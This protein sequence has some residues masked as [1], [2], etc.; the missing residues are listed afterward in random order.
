MFVE[1]FE[2]FNGDLCSF[3]FCFEFFENDYFEN[4][5]FEKKFWWCCVCDGMDVG[6]V[7]EFVEIKWKFV[8][9]DLIGGFFDFVYKNWVEDQVGENKEL[10]IKKVFIEFMEKI[11]FG[12]ISFFIWF[13]FCGCK[14]IVEDDKIGVKVEEELCKKC[15]VGEDIFDEDDEEFDEDEYEYEV[16]FIGDDFVVVIVED[17]WLGVIQYFSKFYLFFLLFFL[18]NC[19]I[20]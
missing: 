2:F 15:K 17:F 11:F 7:S 10:E 20:L 3:F 12:L 13:G 6:Y 16:F 19:V 9:K 18:K 4:K 5:V 8:E 14:F 1:C